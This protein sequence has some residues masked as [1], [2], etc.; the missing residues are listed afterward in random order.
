MRKIE[1]SEHFTARKMLMY[2]LPSIIEVLTVS[3]FQIVDGY[4]IS[5]LQGLL[6]FDGVGMITPVCIILLALGYMFGEGAS[7][8]ISQVMGE[9][10]RKRGNEIFSMILVVMLTAGAAVGAAAAALMPA[11][12]RLVGTTES[13]IGYSIEY[14]RIFALFL[15]AFIVNYG[16]LSLWITAEKSWYGMIV[17]AINGLC[18]AVLDWL[19]MGVLHMGV[20]GAALATSLA[21]TVAVVIT[22]VYFWLPNS[23]SLRLTRF[24]L[25]TFRDLK[26]ICDNGSS[27]MVDSIAGSI[28]AL[29]LNI[30][31]IRYLGEIGVAAMNVYQYVSDFFISVLFGISTTTITVVGYKHGEKKYDELNGLVNT[32]TVLT[33]GLGASLCALFILFAEPIAGIYLG[34]DDAACAAA[35]RAIRILSIQ[36][37]V[38]GFNLFVSSFFTGLGNGVVSVL[39]ALCNSLAA[40]LLMIYALPALFG[41]EALWFAMPAAALLTALVCI[42]MLAT[43]YY[44]KPVRPSL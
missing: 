38:F 41:G 32:N 27:S 23:S 30:Q 13:I 15:P 2:S 19:F 26:Q 22:I 42:G 20:A 25:S 39:I 34:Y 18:N 31:L 28:T 9:G 43:Q 36:C 33:L 4:F 11:L 24:S 1:L 10:D 16:F 3:S 7:A 17:S 14:G 6:P 21:T 29:L 37:I 8:R 5:N 12:A 40:P 35:T 44:R